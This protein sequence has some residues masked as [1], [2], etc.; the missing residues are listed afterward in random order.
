MH[1]DCLPSARWDATILLV[2][3]D[4]TLRARPV[5]GGLNFA[6]PEVDVSTA[7]LGTDSSQTSLRRPRSVCARACAVLHVIAYRLVL[8][9]R[10]RG[11][12]ANLPAR[13]AIQATAYP[14]T[15]QL[16]FS[17]VLEPSHRVPGG[18]E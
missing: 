2:L 4:L 7:S 1:K 3:L 5:R 15:H 14:N 11:D 8:L 18:R 17:W 13:V 12:S 10:V 16:Q 6:L 9:N